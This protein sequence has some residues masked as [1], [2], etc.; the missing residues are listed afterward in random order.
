MC[1]TED[2]WNQSCSCQKSEL[3]LR[4]PSALDTRAVCDMPCLELHHLPPCG[5]AQPHNLSPNLLTGLV[6]YIHNPLIPIH[7]TTDQKKPPDSKVSANIY[8]IYPIHQMHTAYTFLNVWHLSL[9]LSLSGF[10]ESIPKCPL[11]CG[12][13]PRTRCV[14]ASN[15]GFCFWNFGRSISTNSLQKA[16]PAHSSVKLALLDP[17]DAFS[18]TY[19]E[20]NTYTSMMSFSFDEDF[21]CTSCILTMTLPVP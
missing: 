14:V 13:C 4:S 9:S 16:P 15:W 6:L 17:P 21:N 1:Q 19:M 3:C 5:V 18:T 20:K 11:K 10:C 2:D 8:N 7:C 12:W